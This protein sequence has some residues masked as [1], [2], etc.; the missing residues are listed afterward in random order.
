MPS[1][2]SAGHSEPPNGALAREAALARLDHYAAM[3]D[4]QRKDWQ[5]FAGTMGRL[6]ETE[7]VR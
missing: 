3:L 2:G 5:E 6:L 1:Q 4:A 7:V